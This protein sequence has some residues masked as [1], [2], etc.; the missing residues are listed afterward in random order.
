MLGKVFPVHSSVENVVPFKPLLGRHG[1]DDRM[2][3][4][5]DPLLVYGQVGAFAAIV[6]R[7]KR[8]LGEVDLVQIELLSAVSLR[9]LK[10][11]N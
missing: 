6:F 5:I 2:E 8:P 7:L 10:L 1:N 4:R 11:L 3:A 9:A